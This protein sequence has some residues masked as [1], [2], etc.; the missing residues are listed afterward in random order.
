M[1]ELLIVLL[2]LITTG[3]MWTFLMFIGAFWDYYFDPDRKDIPSFLP[4][5]TLAIATSYT[6]IFFLTGV[7]K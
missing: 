2:F 7:I 5:F 1:K 4:Y 3:V 6:V